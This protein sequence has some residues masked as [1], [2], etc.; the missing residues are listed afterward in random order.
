ML[1]RNDRPRVDPLIH[2]DRGDTG[3][4]IAGEDRCWDGT[5]TA[6]SRQERW[7]QIDDASR[8]VTHERRGNDLTKICEQRCL[9]TERLNPFNF[10][11]ITNL[12]DVFNQQSSAAC[13]GVDRGRREGT[14]SAGR[15]WWRRHNSNDAEAGVRCNG[16]ERRDRESAT[17]K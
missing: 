5:R 15:A 7:V 12:C 14:A 16:A 13:P 8:V 10:C 6:M 1:R 4:A 9:R 17:A 3:L 2:H 11:R